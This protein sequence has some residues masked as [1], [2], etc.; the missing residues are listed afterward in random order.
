MLPARFWWLAAEVCSAR[1]QWQQACELQARARRNELD[2]KRDGAAVR[3]AA[4]QLQTDASARAIEAAQRD[5]LTGLGNR[6]RL[7]AVGDRWLAQ[8]MAPIVGQA[9]RGDAFNAINEALG[10]ETGDAVLQAVAERLREACSR[11][12]QALAVRVY[13]DQFAL[14]VAGERTA[15]RRGAAL[16]PRCSP[17]RWPWRG[18]GW[19]SVRHGVSRWAP[20]MGRRCSG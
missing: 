15:C 14:L 11:F 9:E 19:T 18:I 2:S 5:P 10:R 17:R 1:G 8:R 3:R 6:E 7:I 16:P 4:T 13:A 20:C 12:E